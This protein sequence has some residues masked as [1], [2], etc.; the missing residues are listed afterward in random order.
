MK[1]IR[2]ST[3]MLLVVIAALAVA[4]VGERRR[5]AACEARLAEQAAYQR[6]VTQAFLAQSLATTKAA[7]AKAP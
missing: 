7:T 1:R 4:L 3:L 6:A 5:S 2:I